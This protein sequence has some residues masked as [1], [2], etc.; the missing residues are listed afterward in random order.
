MLNTLTHG[1]NSWDAYRLRIFAESQIDDHLQVQGQFVYDD[2]SGVYVDGAYVIFTP[3]A[4]RDL[5]IMGGKQPWMIGTYAPR[6]YS[7]KNPLI[8]TPL[9][10]QYHTSLQWHDIPP[11]ADALLAASG[12][13]Q[14]GVIYRGFPQGS[15]MPIV[16][17]NYWDV[18]I[19]L[20]G[21][22]RPLEYSAGVTAGARELGQHVE[23]GQLGQ[24]RAGTGGLHADSRAATRSVGSV[25]PLPA[26]RPEST[27]ARGA[28][29]ERLPRD[30]GDGR[31][32]GAGGPRRELRAEGAHNRWQTPTV[33]DLDVDAG[34][35]ELK[36]GLASGFYVAGRWDTEQ[37]GKIRDSGGAE[38]PWDW[39]VSRLET[40]IGYRVTRDVTAKLVHQ[41]TERGGGDPTVEDQTD[42]I[43]R[44][45]ALD[46]LLSRSGS[47]RRRPLLPRD[48]PHRGD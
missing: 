43:F 10:Y 29:G 2:A 7:N 4:T 44:S 11:D 30:R 38:H 32:R 41:R 14:S 34:Y 17:E 35:V 28:H 37:F 27:L 22:Q 42:S 18:G 47:R 13:G 24:D 36:Y 21:S 1:D 31:P 12:T 3:W 20:A 16:D 26:R 19:L 15:G 39:N 5:R 46:R 33:G 48:S 45:A 6:T 8:G 40:G 23:R 25:R 9:L